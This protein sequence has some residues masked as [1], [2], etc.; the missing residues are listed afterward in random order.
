VTEDCR[1][2]DLMR[3]VSP[4][5]IALGASTELLAKNRH[6]GAA[7]M[8]EACTVANLHLRY[9]DEK[10][11]VGCDSAAC[12]LCCSPAS[13]VCAAWKLDSN[14]RAKPVPPRALVRSGSARHQKRS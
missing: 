10:V 1:A 13:S 4:R 12:L 11:D 2:A 14:S 3:K 7:N 8:I 9:Y 5:I 6:C